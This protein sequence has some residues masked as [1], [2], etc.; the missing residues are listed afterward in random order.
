MQ[1]WESE[2]LWSSL[3]VAVVTVTLCTPLAVSISYALARWCGPGS[4]ILASLVLLPAALPP[5]VIGYILLAGLSPASA[6]GH[7]LQQ[8]T[9]WH[10]RFFPDGVVLAAS[11]ATLPMMVR[12]LRPHFDTLA[13]QHALALATL[14]ASPWQVWRQLWLPRLAPGILS[15]VCLGLALAWGESGA[16]LVL[17]FALLPPGSQ[18]YAGTVPLALVQALQSPDT[19]DAAARLAGLSCLIV[20]AALLASEALRRHGLQRAALP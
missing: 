9:G 18:S 3:Q 11:A 7:W 19:L 6:F 1:A 12:Q 14:G 16:T 13:P 10:L 5:V 4:W 8:G 2:A 15:A 20:L 17:G